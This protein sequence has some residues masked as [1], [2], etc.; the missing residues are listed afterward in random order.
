MTRSGGTV[1]SNG[2]Y[3]GGRVLHVGQL[4]FDQSLITEVQATG[5][6]ADNSAPVTPNEVDSIALQSAADDFDPFVRHTESGGQTTSGGG[7]VSRV[8][9]GKRPAMAS[10]GAVARG[11]CCP[12]AYRTDGY[13]CGYL[14]C[15]PHDLSSQ[16]CNASS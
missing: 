11:R 8:R 10:V 16:P 12:T 2:T 13:R 14:R 7:N 4:F 15:E 5:A 6:Y 3:S 1:L 9:V